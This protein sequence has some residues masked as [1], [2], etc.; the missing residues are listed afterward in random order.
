MNM[1]S[2]KSDNE[3]LQVL[4][5]IEPYVL[6]EE[7]IRNIESAIDKAFILMMNAPKTMFIKKNKP[8]DV[9]IL[10]RDKPIPGPGLCDMV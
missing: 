3:I 9:P 7:R 2:T 10:P 5:K 6:N 8:I 1:L 4:E